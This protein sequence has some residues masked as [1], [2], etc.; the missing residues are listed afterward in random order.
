M[1]GEDDSSSFPF[2]FK[3]F[4]ILLMKTCSTSDIV[5]RI[6]F[7]NSFAGECWFRKPIKDS[8]ANHKN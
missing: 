3:S 6:L 1:S 4:P 2:S 5:V 7:R 8:S